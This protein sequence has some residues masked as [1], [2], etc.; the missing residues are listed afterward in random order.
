M[1]QGGNNSASEWFVFFVAISESRKYI[2]WN[3]ICSYKRNGYFFCRVTDVWRKSLYFIRLACHTLFSGNT[4]S[5]FLSV[6]LTDQ[7]DLNFSGNIPFYN[8]KGSCRWEG[9]RHKHMWKTCLHKF[10]WSIFQNAS[11][12]N[13]RQCF[14]E[15]DNSE[16]PQVF[17]FYKKAT[18][19][20]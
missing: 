1:A 2:K 11:K 14:P 18:L 3:V 9:V 17:G 5:A 19:T 20:C 15:Y 13:L 7:R 4:F 16:N 8:G 10:H 6:I 12:W